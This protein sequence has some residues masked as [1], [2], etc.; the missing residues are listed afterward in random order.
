[1]TE[2]RKENRNRTDG[3]GQERRKEGRDRT[4]GTGRKGG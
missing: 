1:M 3:T 4:K 2:G